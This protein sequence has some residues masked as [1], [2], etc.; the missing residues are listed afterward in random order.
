MRDTTQFHPLAESQH[1]LLGHV[2]E[3]AQVFDKLSAQALIV[4][5]H[6]GDPTIGI[7]SADELWFI[8][9]GEGVQCYSMIERKIHTFFRRGFPPF[10]LESQTPHWPVRGITF[11][12][13]RT[14]RIEIDP[15][16]E[17]SSMW[18]LELDTLSLS[19]VTD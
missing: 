4:G 8:S 5:E 11:V 16:C 10:P 14:I 3:Q 1:Y 6:Y 12:A 7:I 13:P 18:Q 2:Y 15:L 17:F 19:R 9:G